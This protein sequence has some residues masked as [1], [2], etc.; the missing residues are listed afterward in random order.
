METEAGESSH[1]AQETS[2]E[3]RPSSDKSHPGPTVSAQAFLGEFLSKKKISK[4]GWA[5]RLQ[6]HGVV[7]AL[8]VIFWNFDKPSADQQTRNSGLTPKKKQ[9]Q[10]HFPRLELIN[11]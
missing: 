11:F 8:G 3:G 9:Q 2:W 1:G 5:R 6:C 10:K 7:P 4:S